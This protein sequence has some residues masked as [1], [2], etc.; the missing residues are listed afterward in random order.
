MRVDEAVKFIKKEYKSRPQG[1]SVLHERKNQERQKTAY[2]IAALL[3]QMQAE[4][5]RLKAVA[6]AANLHKTTNSKYYGKRCGNCLNRLSGFCKVMGRTM[7]P[8]SS[9]P[10]WEGGK[11]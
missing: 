3:Q 10:R 5:E 9:C 4:N 6:E 11:A 2:E 8:A 1:C 7:H